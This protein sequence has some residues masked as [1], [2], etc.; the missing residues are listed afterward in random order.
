MRVLSTRLR[1]ILWSAVTA[2][3]DGSTKKQLSRQDVLGPKPSGKDAALAVLT[4]SSQDTT[5]AVAHAESPVIHPAATAMTNSSVVGS[6]QQVP[7]PVQLPAQV[8]NGPLPDTAGTGNKSD[9]AAVA[10]LL[11]AGNT[12]AATHN[13]DSVDHSAAVTEADTDTHAEAT[14]KPV[15]PLNEAAVTDDVHAVVPS[16]GPGSQPG[17]CDLNQQQQRQTAAEMSQHRVHS[18][19]DLE[20][21]YFHME[22]VQRTTQHHLMLQQQLM[23]RIEAFGYELPP[24]L[25]LQNMMQQYAEWLPGFKRKLQEYA[26]QTTKEH[27]VSAVMD[28]TDME[29]C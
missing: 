14:G 23:P 7:P 20:Q 18:Y 19:E 9:L 10:D 25:E 1:L 17:Q 3:A 13:A 11:N 6:L 12:G 5:E 28:G 29:I 24:F 21:L 8:H 26:E 2:K 16:M 27:H 22:H 15:Q 4:F